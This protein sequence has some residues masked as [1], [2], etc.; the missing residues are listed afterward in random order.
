MAED[1]TL[2][3]QLKKQREEILK[4]L[5]EWTEDS[6]FPVNG[7]VYKISKLSHQFRLEVVAIYSQ[8]EANI[9]T[10]N[11][12]FLMNK[13]FK[14]VMKKVDEK[15]LFDNSQIS[16]LPNHFEEYAEDYLDYV[17]ISLKVIS[18]PFYKRKLSIG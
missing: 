18:Y 14:E 1:Q 6:A 17:A 13:D 12:G 4:Q 15:I 7:N 16:K 9:T 5:D 8:I 3:D 10:G 11:Y 2:K